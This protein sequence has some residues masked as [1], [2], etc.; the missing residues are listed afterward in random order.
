VPGEPLE[1]NRSVDRLQRCEIVREAGEAHFSLAPL[2]SA[3]S[4]QPSALPAR[5]R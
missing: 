1:G 5:E 4:T 2:T 3:F